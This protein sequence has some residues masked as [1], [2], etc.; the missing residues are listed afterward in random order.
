MLRKRRTTENEPKCILEGSCFIMACQG[1]P[2]LFIS[3]LILFFLFVLTSFCTCILAPIYCFCGIPECK[4]DWVSASCVSSCALFCWIWIFVFCL[5]LM[6][7]FSCFYYILFIIILV[8]A[9]YLMRDKKGWIQNGWLVRRTQEELSCKKIIIK[10]YYVRKINFN[11][12]K[13][14]LTKYKS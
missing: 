13:Q 2:L 11:K 12:I 1:S 10:L 5:L 8:D 4:N 14:K 7:L 3:I 6:C 9:Y